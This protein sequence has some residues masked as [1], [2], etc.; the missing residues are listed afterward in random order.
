MTTSRFRQRAAFA[1]GWVAFAVTTVAMLGALWFDWQSLYW[2]AQSAVDP[3]SFADG[4][5]FWALYSAVS[6]A[7]QAVAAL[8]PILLVTLLAAHAVQ[9]RLLR[10]QPPT[11]R[12]A[13]G[14]EDVG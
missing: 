1:V 5:R 4:M 6:P 3:N 9:W 7:R 2:S 14:D 13:A 10:V 11:R 12:R 8:A